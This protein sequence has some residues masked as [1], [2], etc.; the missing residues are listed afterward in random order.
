MHDSTLSQIVVVVLSQLI[1][2]WWQ[3]VL[4]LNAPMSSSD[5]EVRIFFNDLQAQVVWENDNED[6]NG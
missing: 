5:K 2:S 6:G 4:V 3:H 1:S